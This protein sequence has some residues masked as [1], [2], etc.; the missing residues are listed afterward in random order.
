MLCSCQI[1]F[2]LACK[3][4][5][6]RKLLFLHSERKRIVFFA[7]SERA[8][9]QNSLI[10][11]HFHNPVDYHNHDDRPRCHHHQQHQ[12]KKNCLEAFHRRRIYNNNMHISKYKVC[13]AQRHYHYI[14]LYAISLSSHFS[15]RKAYINTHRHFEL[16]LLRVMCS[17]AWV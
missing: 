14:I 2:I 12:K 15:F 10:F 13:V 11:A 7:L 8:A 17:I 3:L 6:S 9:A 5:L 1:S 4:V 16:D